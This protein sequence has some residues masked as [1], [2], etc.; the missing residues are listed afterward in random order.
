MDARLHLAVAVGEWEAAIAAAE[1]QGNELLVQLLVEEQ[2][3]LFEQAIREDGYLFYP[4]H[5]DLAQGP[6]LARRYVTEHASEEVEVS[7]PE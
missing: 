7:N 3:L 2:V 6:A 4:G 5:T 1:A